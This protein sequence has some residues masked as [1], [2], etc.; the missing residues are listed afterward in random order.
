MY[1]LLMYIGYLTS[2]SLSGAGLLYCCNKEKFYE[3]TEKIGWN[4]VRYYHK[5]NIEMRKFINNME[6]KNLASHTSKEDNEN[7]DE[8]QFV[9][10]NSGSTFKCDFSELKEDKKDYIESTDFD[11]MFL[12][13]KSEEKTLWKRIMQKSELEN[14][15]IFDFVEESKPFLQ[16]EYCEKTNESDVNKTEIH[17]EMPKFYIKNNKILDN[18]FLKWYLF[19]FMSMNIGD[20]YYLH[21]IDK[22]INM[23]K[24]EKEQLCTLSNDEYKIND[25]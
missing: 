13:K 2:I 11:L 8:Y 16:I 9:G 14:T 19:K 4:S 25:M 23:F 24:M 7:E 3:L 18:T 10:I 17:Q 20:D 22:D 12:C 5:I 6:N 1:Q 15:N 21:I